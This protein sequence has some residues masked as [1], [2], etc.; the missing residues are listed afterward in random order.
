MTSFVSGELE[1]LAEDIVTRLEPQLAD[2][3]AQVASKVVADVTQLIEEK[4]HL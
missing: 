1:K 2:L 4:F 3:G